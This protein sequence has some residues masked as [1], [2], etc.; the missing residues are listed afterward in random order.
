MKSIKLLHLLIFLI[1]SINTFGQTKNDTI[2]AQNEVR[3]MLKNPTNKYN[4]INNKTIIIKDRLT[5]INVAEPIL[6]GV[7]G[8]ANIIKQKPYKIFFI[9]NYWLIKGTLPKGK[10]GGTFQIIIDSRNSKVIDIIHGK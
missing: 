1:L 5:A 7:F 2:N 9:D 4:L 6:F 10:I 8:K 3:Y